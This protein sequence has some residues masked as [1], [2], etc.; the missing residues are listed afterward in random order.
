MKLPIGIDLGTTYSAIGKWVNSFAFTGVQVYYCPTEN[1]NYIASKIYIKD[2]ADHENNIVVGKL[3]IRKSFSDPDHYFSA[4][5]RGMDDNT[6]IERLDGS[7]KPVELSSMMLRHMIEKFV[8]PIEGPDFMP[9]GVVVSV[10]YYFTEPPCQHTREALSL[11]LDRIYHDKNDFVIEEVNQKTVAEPIAAGLD[12]AFTHSYEIQGRQN[13]LVFDLG[14]GTFDVTLYE[15]DNQEANQELHFKVLATDGDAR[16]GGEDFDSS[17][18]DFVIKK[19]GHNPEDLRDPVFKT[20]LPKLAD[21]VTECKCDLSFNEEYQLF[22]TPYGNEGDLDLVVTRKDI[23]QIM[24]GEKGNGIDYLSK[25]EDIVERC[26]DKS[27]LNPHNVDRVI[28]VGGSSRMPCIRKMLEYK[29]GAEKVYDSDNPSETVARGATIWAAYKLDQRN[30]KIAEDLGTPLPKRYLDKW[31]KIVITEVTAHSLGVL[32]SNGKVD[33]MIS[34]GNFT[35]AKATRVYR[36]SELSSDGKTAVLEKLV[37][38]QGKDII[39]TIPIPVIYAH[40]RSKNQILITIT[41]I[42]ESTEIKVHISVPEGNEDRSDIHVDG[43]IKIS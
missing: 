19:T 23:E 29:F 38:R 9:D 40:G 42:A 27:G 35:P 39:G 12:Y 11:A 36:P 43:E 5:K 41:L 37:V 4:F 20:T 3:A 1:Q 7:I 2:L 32:L 15:I 10:P 17:I 6:D 14:G 22:V 31:N 30:K 16:L 33:T 34:E 21:A 8:I 24:S 13:I 18:R 25:I 28:T 26:I